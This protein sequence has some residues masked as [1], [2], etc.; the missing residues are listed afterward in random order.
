M[1]SSFDNFL[2]LGMFGTK[3]FNRVKSSCISSATITSAG[4]EEGEEHDGE[5]AK[6]I[7]AFVTLFRD[8]PLGFGEEDEEVVGD[9]VLVIFFDF[10]L[11]SLDSRG[12]L[13]IK[14]RILLMLTLTGV[15]DSK[16]Q[17]KKTS[18]L[19]ERKTMCYSSTALARLTSEV[20]LGLTFITR[21]S[22]NQSL[23][24]RTRL[25]FCSRV[26]SLSVFL[27]Q[28]TAGSE[29]TAGACRRVPFSRS[30]L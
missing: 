23:Q 19:G 7:F 11:S 24:R 16:N 12:D 30:F 20:L 13:C 5:A 17:L 14:C 25:V 28:R 29:P 8:N 15:Q 3:S 4:D 27:L 9:V 18:F 6:C 26:C 1:I 2:F 22:L 21:H 10:L